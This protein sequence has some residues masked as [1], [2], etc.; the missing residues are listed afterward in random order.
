[1]KKKSKFLSAALALCMLAGLLS[2]C[3]MFGSK[4]PDPAELLAN[5]IPEGKTVTADVSL[6]ADFSMDMSGLGTDG[7]TMS[8]SMD[9]GVVLEQS[10]SVAHM[11]G[12]AKVSFFG[13]DMDAPIDTWQEK[14][15][16]TVR[17]Y[18]LDDET[19]E[20][21]YEDSEAGGGSGG[22][23]GLMPD[24]GKISGLELDESDKKA[25]EWTVKGTMSS[26]DLDMD[27]AELD[28]INGDFDMSAEI[29]FD[30][31]TG[32]MTYLLL[33]AGPADIDGGR[34]EKLRLEMSNILFGDD[35]L[36]VPEDVKASAF[37][38][39]GGSDDWGY[40]GNDG[41]D[42]YGWSGSGDGNRQYSVGG[43]EFR[44]GH[45]GDMPM[46]AEGT[47]GFKA[48]VA[49]VDGDY[50]LY[51]MGVN[52]TS[53]NIE[54]NIGYDLYN[55]DVVFDDGETWLDIEAGCFAIGEFWLDTDRSEP[56]GIVAWAEQE[57]YVP[58]D[59]FGND[60]SVDWAY[61]AENYRID[62][63]AN[64]ETDRDAEWTKVCAAF[65]NGNDLVYYQSTYADGDVLEAG[66]RAAFTM[67][68]P[69]ELPDYDNAVFYV[70]ATKK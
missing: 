52:Q 29:R 25:P 9:M 13:M 40:G 67:Y 23:D 55:G 68:L 62:G 21:F 6:L 35:A 70:T 1:M 37:P 10:D 22:I 38:A 30:K 57:A 3:S 50:M 15:G 59:E 56:T 27:V 28:G 39:A 5:G 41:D 61:D 46:N 16:S 8:M 32:H 24:S 18:E 26:K 63:Y 7:A 17:A 44:T 42:G 20:W 53:K 51:V 36:S 12:S 11:A 66:G 65:F 54:L 34:I 14:S 43:G 47:A 64:N 48:W 4:A 33:E 45:L 69:A 60:M 19:G 49:E 31:K 58:E 2:G